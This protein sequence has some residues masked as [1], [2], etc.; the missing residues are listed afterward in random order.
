MVT[1]SYHG[2]KWSRSGCPGTYYDPGWYTSKKDGDKFIVTNYKN[3]KTGKR[4]TNAELAKLV[5]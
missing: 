3:P 2:K 1:Y 5:K 4:Y